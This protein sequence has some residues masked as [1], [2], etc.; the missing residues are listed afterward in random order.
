MLGNVVC[1]A[2][3]FLYSHLWVGCKD[4]Q[5]VQ[6]YWVLFEKLT[7]FFG[8]YRFVGCKVTKKTEILYEVF[9][10]VLPSENYYWT[11]ISLY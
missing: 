5:Q 9:S 2:L 7:H 3:P 4:N 8:Q 6:N 11:A 1:T 10:H